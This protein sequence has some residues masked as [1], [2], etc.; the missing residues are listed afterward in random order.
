MDT[1]RTTDTSLA[2]LKTW[3]KSPVTLT[4]PGWVIAATAAAA[5]VLVV[6]A[7]D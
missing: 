3:L 2:R 1:Q 7:L 4:L 5:L 6:L